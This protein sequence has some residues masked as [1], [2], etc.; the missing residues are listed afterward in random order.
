MMTFSRTVLCRIAAAATFACVALTGADAAHAQSAGRNATISAPIALPVLGVDAPVL[1]EWTPVAPV[2][3][4]RLHVNTR[5]AAT[6]TAV[7][8]TYELQISRSAD[9]TIDL[10]YDRVVP[11]TTYLFENTGDGDSSFVRNPEATNGLSDGRYFWRVRALLGGPASPYSPLSTFNLRR[12]I[13]SAATHDIGIASL[14]IAGKPV[15]GR[16]TPIVARVANIGSFDEPSS[17]LAFTANGVL[18]GTATVPP[19]GHGSDTHRFADVSVPWTP[20][21]GPLAAIAVQFAGVDQDMRNNTVTQSLYVA[22]APVVVTTIAG[23]LVARGSAYAVVD[24]HNRP[25]A[26]L[27]Q[28]ASDTLDYATFVGRTV[29]VRGELETQGSEL[30][31]AV[32]TFRAVAA[33][34]KTR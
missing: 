12:G 4:Y 17:T 2:G 10:L 6:T 16:T 27:R 3:A 26:L 33:P 22:P 28:R 32:S 21:A 20:S 5:T 34:A 31:L 11:A 15:V 30:I 29:E 9:F 13:T 14:R 23:T 18:I 7:A 24:A 1:F 25:L 8:V 19:L